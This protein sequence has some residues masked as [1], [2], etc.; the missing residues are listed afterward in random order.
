MGLDFALAFYMVHE[1]PDAG[2]FFIE[3]A[4]S[5]KPG[6]KLLIAEPK[7][8]V[9]KAGFAEEEAAAE[10]AGFKKILEPKILF[11]YAMLL[12]KRQG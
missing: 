5:L 1:V 8:R 12:E 10:E 2:R 3:V 4:D 7:M 9:S 6:G 11:S